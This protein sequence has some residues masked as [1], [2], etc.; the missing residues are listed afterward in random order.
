MKSKYQFIS[1]LADYDINSLGVIIKIW[2]LYYKLQ[3]EKFIVV[4]LL[5]IFHSQK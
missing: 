5:H 4:L 2:N 1:S 3:I